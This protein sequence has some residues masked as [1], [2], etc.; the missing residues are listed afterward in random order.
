MDRGIPCLAKEARHGAPLFVVASAEQQVPLGFAQDRL[1]RR[2]H[3]GWGNSVWDGGDKQQ[4]PRLRKIIRVADDLSPLGMTG[5]FCGTTEVVFFP[6][7]ALPNPQ[8]DGAVDS[9]V[10]QKKRDTGHPFSWWCRLNSR[11]LTGLQPD[12]E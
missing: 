11:F 2:V 7:A 10:S 3:E 4:V 8:R 9:H 1:L 6:V 5:L 12:S